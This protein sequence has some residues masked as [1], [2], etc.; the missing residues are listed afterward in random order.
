MRRDPSRWWYALVPFPVLVGLHYGL[1]GL[2][3]LLLPTAGP[4][5]A[6]A[7]PVL[8]AGV[9]TSLIGAIVVVTAPLFLVGLVLDVRTLRA[10]G[11]W[12]PHWGYVVLG[13]PPVVGVFVEWVALLSI[14]AAIGYLERRRRTTGHPFGSGKADTEVSTDATQPSGH[15]YRS[16]WWYGVVLPP[17]L[18]L[19]GGGIVWIVRTMGLLRQG[20]DPLTLLVPIAIIGVAIG[21]IPIFAISLYLDA[22]TVSDGSSGGI[23]N[24]QIWGLL[25]IGALLGLVLVRLSF[26]PLVAIAYLVRRR[27]ATTRSTLQ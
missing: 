12:S 4:T 26:M 17:L 3:A 21:L 25:G 2:T 10:R 22:K 7:L 6:E 18:E 8:L 11:T 27:G 19:T 24:P 20:S 5:R 23:S 15:A 14:P 1:E 9:A 16:R 13:V